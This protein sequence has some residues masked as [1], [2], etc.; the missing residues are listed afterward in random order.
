MNT[1]QAYNVWYRVH[2]L[3]T[4]QDCVDL[5]VQVQALTLWLQYITLLG[6]VNISAPASVHWIFSAASFAFASVTSRALSTD[7][8]QSGTTN[9]AVQRVLLHLA[10][11][12]MV[13]LLLLAIQALWCV[14]QCFY[15][16]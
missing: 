8:L 3:A 15:D 6:N 12:V 7:C 5:A 2:L 16:A 1:I 11:P 13:L 10:V 9:A 14:R 4:V